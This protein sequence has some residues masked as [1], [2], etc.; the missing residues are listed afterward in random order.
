MSADVQSQPSPPEIKTIDKLVAIPIVHDS[1]S[2]LHQTLTTYVPTAY[3]YGQALTTSAY[4]LSAPLQVR[5]APLIVSADGYALKGLDAA[6]AKFPTPFTVKTEDVVQGIKTRKDNAVNAVTRPVYGLANGV[7]SSLTPIVDRIEAALHNT[8]GAPAHTAEA[9]DATSSTTSESSSAS[10]DQ[11][12]APAT[13]QVGRLYHLSVDVKNQIVVLSSEQLKNLQ[14]QNVYI[15]TATERLHTLNESLTRS[16]VA[17]KDKS[18]EIVHETRN[19][20]NVYTNNILAE[21]EKVQAATL[22][23]PKNLQT[24]LAPVREEIESSFHE[25]TAIVKSSD[26]PVG[27]KV[28]KVGHHVQDKVQP[29]LAQTTATIQSYIDKYVG[30]AKEKEG[31][32]KETAEEVK[33]SANGAVEEATSASS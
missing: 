14:T 5:L 29:L 20:A 27:E 17:T 7:D 22:A 1:L 2:T 16:Y 32:A 9:S 3:G 33:E 10:S 6:Q 18:I 4:S 15:Q 12:A 21:L 26:L 25:I 23:L 31:E 19:Q 28:A 11:A 13:T 24:H 30:K 8:L